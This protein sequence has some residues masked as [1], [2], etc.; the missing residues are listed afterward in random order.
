LAGVKVNGKLPYWIL[1][2]AVI[3]P[4]VSW[5]N[6]AGGVVSG[7]EYWNGPSGLFESNAVVRAMAHHRGNLFVGGVFQRVAGVSATN[8]VRWDGTNWFALGEGVAGTIEAIAVNDERVFVGGQFSDASGEAALNVA[9]WDGERWSSLGAGLNNVVFEL[10][11][12]ADELYAGG[13]FTASGSNA[14]SRVARW[15]GTNWQAVGGGVAGGAGSTFVA[16]LATRGS[17]VYVGGSFA[18][19]GSIAAMNIAKW[20]GT[21]WA[22]LGGGVNATVHALAASPT[23]V[24]VGGSFNAAS[25]VSASNIAFWD[26]TNW[27]PLGTGIVSDR[28]PGLASLAL[29]GEEL[30]VGG[31]E[32]SGAGNVS[33]TNIVRW[34][35][36]G[37]AAL[38]QGVTG[39][40]GGSVNAMAA[41]GSE[42]FVGGYFDYAGGKVANHFAVWSVPHSLSVIQTANELRLSW[43]STGTNFVLEAKGDVVVTNWSEVSPPPVVLNNECVVTNTVNGAQRVYRLR[44]R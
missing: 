18:T 13:Q 38:G 20:N 36:D 19:A 14:M 33:S 44:R 43:P 40:F 27:S 7:D 37:W 6:V 30:Y 15:D 28:S 5:Q 42:I 32:F 35:E 1:K 34:T 23:G 16:A 22:A 25:T 2:L 21:N 3:L 17:E 9:S 41:N 31:V 8:I 4:L 26:G 10:V 12:G 11:I 29:N 24:Y 39:R